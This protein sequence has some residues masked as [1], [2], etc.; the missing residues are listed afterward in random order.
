MK[1]VLIITLEFPPYVGGVAT[2]VHDLAMAL[3][4][5]KTVVLAPAGNDS[6]TTKQQK[7]DW[8]KDKKYKIIRRK[9]LFPKFIWPRWL[10]LIWHVWRVVRKE[11]IEIIFVQ[12]VLPVGYSAIVMKKLFKVPF[13]LFSHGTDL[14]AGTATIWKRKMVTMVSKHTDQIIFN[15]NS[16][17]S[18]YL[19]VLPQFENKSFV[20][21]PCPEPRFLE[22]P[23]RADIDNLRRRYALEGKQT[24]LSVSRL[25]EGKGFPS[26]IR[27]MPKILEQVPNL[28]WF[29]IGGG[30]KTDLIIDSI[31]KYN[32]QNVVRFVGE[33]PHEDLHPYF[34]TSDV[35]VLLTH[36]DEGK[37]EGL[38]L[39]FLEASAAGLPIVAGRSGGVPEAVLDGRTGLIVD[40]HNEKQ[41]V[42][43]VLKLLREKAYASQLGKAAKERMLKDFQWHEQIKLLEPWIG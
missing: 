30:F 14:V 12:Q 20:L 13:L 8:D 24:L 1:R 2:Y 23:P 42:D 16:L 22:P 40:A 26:M 41:V 17:M 7:I 21:Y 37:E 25:D 38:G 34:Y 18:R 27:C 43:S 35:F 11:K 6:F 32:L 4:P 3:D 10:R 31:R 33:I 9:L 28:V 19:R 15:S 5:E 39:V 29:I 36:P